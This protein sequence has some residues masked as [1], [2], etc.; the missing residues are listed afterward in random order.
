L[1]PVLIRGERSSRRS[2]GGW[3]KGAR[4]WFVFP[5]PPG[6]KHPESSRIQQIKKGGQDMVRKVF[7]LA[8]FFS[9]ALAVAAG[10]QDAA[11]KGEKGFSMPQMAPL[12]GQPPYEYRDGWGMTIF[13]KTTPEA[14]KALIPSPL[15][16]N[17][18]NLMLVVFRHLF[19]RGF[20][21]Y[22]EVTLIAPA[23]FEG[24]TVH[25]CLYVMAD[26]DVDNGSG[27]E[28]WGFPQ[29]GGT[30][31]V[32]EKDGNLIGTA[33]RSGIR[34]IRGAMELSEIGDTE[35]DNPPLVNLKIIPSVKKGAPPEVMQLTSTTMENVRNHRVYTGE[36]TL[37]FGAS[38]SDP[39]HKIPIVEVLGGRYSDTDFTLTYGNIIHDYLKAPKAK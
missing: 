11:A 5:L 30:I 18:E 21:H 20:G 36:A 7:L 24:Q 34:L 26:N 1:S 29:K 10:P 35:I 23:V 13:F 15:V 16:P 14:L 12:Y 6:E 25:Y 28:I 22:S 3:R 19:A 32:D 8:C 17:P 27:R 38:P 4:V 2:G 31:R 39:F 37:E 33:E 9:F